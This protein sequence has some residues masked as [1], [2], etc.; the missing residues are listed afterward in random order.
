MGHCRSLIISCAV[1]TTFYDRQGKNT[2]CAHADTRKK[3][4]A[5]V[6]CRRSACIL[7]PHAA[8]INNLTRLNFSHTA[9]RTLFPLP[10]SFSLSTCYLVLEASCILQFHMKRYDTSPQPLNAVTVAYALFQMY[11]ICPESIC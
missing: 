2:T 6:T 8:T 3:C 11:V 1:G 10:F 9:A 4:G 5:M 7:H